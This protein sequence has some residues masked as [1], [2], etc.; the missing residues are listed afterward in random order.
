MRFAPWVENAVSNHPWDLSGTPNTGS[1]AASTGCVGA[2]CITNDVGAPNPVG[3]WLYQ[4]LVTTTGQT[5]NLS[6]FFYPAGTGTNE[7][8]V[9]W[10]GTTVFDQVDIP[11]DF[12][13]KQYTFSGLAATSGTTRLEFLARQDLSS[14]GLDDVCVSSTQDCSQAATV[15]ERAT[16]FL[17]GSALVGMHRLVRGRR[18]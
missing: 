3:A 18:S 16:I 4:D 8:R 10:G 6:F 11:N 1:V 9:L 14:N 13:Y 5:Y 7:L 12:V 2:Q 17:V 15:P